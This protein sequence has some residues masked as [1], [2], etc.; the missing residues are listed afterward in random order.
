M[1]IQEV[2]SPNTLTRDM[3]HPRRAE[4]PGSRSNPSNPLDP[5]NR[6]DQGLGPHSEGKGW[7]PVDLR[8]PEGPVNPASADR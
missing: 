3:G 5:R 8:D 1:A 7:T 4:S 6:A 2:K